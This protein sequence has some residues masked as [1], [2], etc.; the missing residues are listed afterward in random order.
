MA[1]NMPLSGLRVL[2]LAG[3]IAAAY[4]AKML[5]DGGATVLLAEPPGGA[6]LRRRKAAAAMGLIPP[7]A[8]GET[9]GLFGY[10]SR[11]KQPIL[12]DNDGDA[13]L[14]LCAEADIL[15][16]DGA[17]ERFG[18][19]AADLQAAHPGLSVISISHWGA[20]GPAAGK[21]ATEFTLQAETGS[22]AMRGDTI[23][24]P[25]ATRGELGDYI[26]GT[27]AAIAAL[28]ASRMA[29]SG[30]GKGRLVDVSRFEAMLICLQSYQYIH[31]QMEAGLA[32]AS[33]DVPAIER[34]RD[35]WVGY[36]TITDRQWR[37][38]ATMIGHPEL[39]EDDSIRFGMQRFLQRERVQPLIDAYMSE[40]TVAQLVDE[41]LAYRIPVTPVG[42]PT[43]VMEMEHFKARNVF[44]TVPE[45]HREPR[46][47]YCISGVTAPDL[48]P[49]PPVPEPAANSEKIGFP[50]RVRPETGDTT[51]LSGLRVVD[52][53]AFWAGPMASF[54]LGVLGADVIKVEA[55]Q[56]PDGM[57]YAGGFV[58][59]GKPMW[60]CSPIFLGVN[61]AKRS[62]TLDLTRKEGLDLVRQLIAEC[63][64]VIENFSPRVMES[65]GL[66]WEDIHAINPR[67]IMLRMPA[68]GLDGPWRDRTGFAMTIEQVSGLAAQTGYPDG[69]PSTPRGCVDPVGGINGAF[70]VLAALEL[71]ER[72]GLGRMVE[73]SLAEAGIAISA[74]A[75]IDQQLDGVYAG[76]FGNSGP[77]AV[78]QAVLPCTDGAVALSIASDDQWQA[79][80]R[81]CPGLTDEPAWAT[82]SGRRADEAAIVA[83]LNQWAAGQTESA[84]AET[85]LE[86]G[87]PAAPLRNMRMLFDHPQLNARGFLE[88]M[89]HAVVGEIALPNLPFKIDGDYPALRRPAPM[90]GEHNE[91]V[92]AGELGLDAARIAELEH[93][94][95]IGRQP[96]RA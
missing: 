77:S 40:R 56:R 5:A 41:A 83:R 93:M 90:L 94:S 24:P 78:P 53:S 67:A 68:F 96:V 48:P 79:L 87:I 59:K 71:R 18:L 16:E 85:L 13:L 27:F 57:R 11:R 43:T 69:T 35:G 22:L 7:P 52:F 38:F 29:R 1:D 6:D 17:L 47:P 76:R 14:A 34:A 51:P 23:R 4:A 10:L 63:D 44:R 58:P 3:G 46:P 30:N 55:A 39:G 82:A 86:H 66:G 54:V 42:D 95:I 45:G 33:L 72:D 81:L 2:E 80:V 15:V 73:A 91:E 37:D 92:L 75:L 36:A 65:F 25:F 84:L 9:N 20:D 61:S 19:R 74:E 70:G 64:V 12:L 88:R 8:D 50:E 32:P 31:G 26:S 89:T 60:E 21:P 28:A 62:V 49:V